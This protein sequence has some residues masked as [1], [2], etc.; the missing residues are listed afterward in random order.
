MRQNRVHPYVSMSRRH[1]RTCRASC[2]IPS[3]T[4]C[5]HSQGPGSMGSQALHRVLEQLRE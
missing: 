2:I 1:R 3:R 5:V 4:C